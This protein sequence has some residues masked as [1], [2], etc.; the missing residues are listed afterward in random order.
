MNYEYITK[1]RHAKEQQSV[2]QNLLK[3]G[4]KALYHIYWLCLHGQFC[5][6]NCVLK[7]ANWLNLAD[8]D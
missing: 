2:K 8:D 7:G 4:T 5:F 1:N 3:L 6:V